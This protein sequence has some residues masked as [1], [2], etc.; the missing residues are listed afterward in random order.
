MYTQHFFAIF[1]YFLIC[2][3]CIFKKGS[4][5]HLRATMP[6]LHTWQLIVCLKLSKKAPQIENA[7]YSSS[8]SRKLL[9]PSIG[10][11]CWM[12][13]YMWAS[14]ANFGIGFQR[15]YLRPRQEFF[16]MFLPLT[17][18]NMGGGFARWSPTAALIHFGH[19]P[20]PPHPSQS[21]R[22]RPSS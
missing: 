19:W 1:W 9:T 16:S 12:F 3:K 7:I 15:L 21:H 17:P 4:N 10:A 6:C 18:L 13:F 20:S 14:L 22:S 2:L 11:T 8:T 5:M